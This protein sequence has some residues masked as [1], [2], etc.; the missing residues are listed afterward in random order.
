MYNLEP[1]LNIINIK[2]GLIVLHFSALAGNK[3][4]TEF[5]FNIN[6]DPNVL[7]EYSETPLQLTRTQKIKILEYTD[8]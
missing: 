5:F 2:G 6:V 7:S 8:N 3:E 4:I 1:Y